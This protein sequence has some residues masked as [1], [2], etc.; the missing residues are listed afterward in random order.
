MIYRE[1]F[2]GPPHGTTIAA[3]VANKNIKVISFE[4]NENTQRQRSES[5]YALSDNESSSIT[6]S[7]LAMNA[8]RICCNSLNLFKGSL[9]F[10]ILKWG[11]KAKCCLVY[12]SSLILRIFPLISKEL[13][14]ILTMADLL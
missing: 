12:G 7:K 2:L 9:D 5:Y 4:S 1:A 10:S 6:L 3:A 11:Q 14:V 8:R 13:N